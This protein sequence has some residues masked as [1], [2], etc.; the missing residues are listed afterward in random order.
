MSLEMWPFFV[1]SAVFHLSPE[2]S[3]VFCKLATFPPQSAFPAPSFLIWLL[4]SPRVSLLQTLLCPFSKPPP[5]P[6]RPSPP[7]S[8]LSPHPFCT[9]QSC[10]TRIPGPP[11]ESLLPFSQYTLS[12]CHSHLGP[13][14]G[15][16]MLL[17]FL[18]PPPSL[19]KCLAQKSCSTC[20]FLHRAAL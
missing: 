7:P 12:M 9:C 15:E 6:S 17:S 3:D 19:A 20:R 4:P 13:L 5:S 18:F 1:K 10:F 16:G 11:S 14:Q 2:P 8:H